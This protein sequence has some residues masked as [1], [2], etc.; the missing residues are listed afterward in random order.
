[1]GVATNFAICSEVAERIELCL[2]NDD[3]HEERV[4][5]PERNGLIW[6]GYL[7]RVWPGARDGYR[8]HGPY[9]PEAVLRCTPP[10]LLLDPYAKATDGQ[11]RWDEALFSYRFADP[12]A[13]ND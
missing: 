4:V 3:G 9:A 13:F 5:L 2:V 7:P 8:V 6:H 10:K 1:R 12:G 11:Y